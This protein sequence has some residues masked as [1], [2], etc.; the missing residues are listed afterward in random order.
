[1][2]PKL[3]ALAEAILALDFPVNEALH[4][5]YGHKRSLKIFGCLSPSTGALLTDQI[6]NRRLFLRHRTLKKA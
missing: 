3:V 6:V 1:M 2:S 4:R 5:G